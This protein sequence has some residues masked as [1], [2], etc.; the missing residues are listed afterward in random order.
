MT[1]ASPPPTPAAQ[2]DQFELSLLALLGRLIE[3][4][5][6]LTLLARSLQSRGPQ[7][8]KDLQLRW[9]SPEGRERTWHVECKSHGSAT[10]P[11]KEFADKILAAGRSFHDIDVWCLA[12]AHAEPSAGASELLASATAKLGLTFAVAVLSPRIGFVKRLYACHPD[13]Y[14]E[15]YGA[16]PPS[17]TRGERKRA[18]EDFGAWLEAESARKPVATL[19]GW[20]R[21]G[22][23]AVPLGED[24]KPLAAT[25]LR[26]LTVTCPWE[27][28][29]H[30]W[31]VPRPSAEKALKEWV[32]EKEAGIRVRWLI[33]AG[34]EGKSTVLRR[35]AWDCAAAGH[36]VLFASQDA[37]AEFPAEVVD[38][39]P[40]GSTVLL[41]VDGSREFA[42]LGAVTEAHAAA[43]IRDDKRVSVLIGDRGSQWRRNRGRILPG[44]VRAKHVILGPLTAPERT[45]LAANLD[46]RGL[47]HGKSRQE[48]VG[49]LDA[50]A[51]AAS[52]A[53]LQRAER[54]WLLPT[55]MALT[56][57]LSR[58]FDT[59]LSSVLSELA[60][61]GERG[62]LR[63]LLLTSL[64][65]A[66]GAPF[67]R[68]LAE[69]LLKG[70]GGL[71]DAYEALTA[72]LHRQFDI[73]VGGRP[74][75]E[76]SLWTHGRMVSDGF[77]RVAREDP[78]TKAV[79][80]SACT[81]LPTAMA[82]DRI[83]GVL[84]PE[85]FELLDLV[86]AYLDDEVGEFE[87]NTK[88]LESWID[89]EPHGFPAWNR[90]GQCYLHWLQR[91]LRSGDSDDGTLVALATASREAF[92][93]AVA[94]TDAVLGED[95]RPEPYR[96]YDRSEKQR[97]N[98]RA[99]AL[100]E[101]V[102]GSP[103]HERVGGP[104]E[105]VRAEFL[106]LLG[107]DLSS[108]RDAPFALG[109]LA[110]VLLN[111]GHLTAAAAVTAALRDVAGSD[112]HV[113]RRCERWL[114]A[115][116]VAVPDGGIELLDD[117][118][119]QE[120]ADLSGQVEDLGVTDDR[121]SAI[122]MLHRALQH[123][124]ED[125]PRRSAIEGVMAELTTGG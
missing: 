121:H 29:A 7:Y 101:A 4:D 48:A 33:G 2:G 74:L 104:P 24:S 11:E 57:P 26:G 65:H 19:R 31:A 46:L 103:G 15:Q 42:G 106:C 120:V 91:E 17:M 13:L 107:L 97:V 32:A 59:I 36:H 25:Y 56:D 110:Q 40:A 9:L 118:L 54:G 18:V 67:P 66:A 117:V 63:L 99:W 22:D 113:V 64:V 85:R 102:L 109:V 72:E 105:L 79:L 3:Q 5:L 88:L 14:R 51:S 116:G 119:A 58:P 28:I 21:V 87:A 1:T 86:E 60:D 78:S 73:P 16:A 69:S 111:R 115:K 100:L 123:V 76:E 10:V 47:L 80:R 95:R 8:G 94:L 30:G 96:S 37:P 114:D 77:V 20:Q 90:L 68:T 41:C 71:D 61:T 125:L 70:Y 53:S 45:A 82:G 124:A 112:D 38:A 89:V 83:D 62:S 52:A 34:G 43:W 93:Q 23:G 6:G 98:Y 49:R 12:L 27:A 44:R 81:D 75:V 35:V 108:R 92:R 55:V 84:K 39:L 122:G 50:A